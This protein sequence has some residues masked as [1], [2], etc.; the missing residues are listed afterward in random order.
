MYKPLSYAH[1]FT[2]SLAHNGASFN[3]S[4]VT[5]I[6]HT[7][8]GQR[9]AQSIDKAVSALYNQIDGRLAAIDQKLAVSCLN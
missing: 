3:N 4:T 8:A 1:S 6:L 9:R 2:L 5:F 7:K